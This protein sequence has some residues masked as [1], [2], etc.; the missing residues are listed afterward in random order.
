MVDTAL[1][2][3]YI[4][5]FTMLSHL[6]VFDTRDSISIINMTI[7][8]WPIVLDKIIQLIAIYQETWNLV[9]NSSRTFLIIF[10]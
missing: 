3:P 9:N 2:P 10:S 5:Y 7:C 4:L 1:C 6:W 8:E